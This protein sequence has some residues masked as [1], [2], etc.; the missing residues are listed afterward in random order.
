M[1]WSRALTNGSQQATPLVCD[2]VLYMPNPDDVIQVIDAVTGDLLWDI[3]GR[4]PP[5]SGSSSRSIPPIAT[6]PSTTI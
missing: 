1:V 2:G 6:S 4:F 3:G 5:M